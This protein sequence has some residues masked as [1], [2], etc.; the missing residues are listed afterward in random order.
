MFILFAK[1]STFY[2]YSL[3]YLFRSLEY[4]W[5]LQNDMG[6]RLARHFPF[7]TRL[8]SLLCYKAA[9]KKADKINDN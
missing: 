5:K 7:K 1:I 8:K 6:V 4:V 3:P 2:V 9:Q